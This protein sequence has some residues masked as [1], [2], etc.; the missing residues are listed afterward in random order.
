M[1]DDRVEAGVEQS[2]SNATPE[3]HPVETGM[4]RDREAA[5][6]P[7]ARRWAEDGEH[8]PSRTGQNEP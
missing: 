7:A 5:N 6:H 3:R 1:R 8:H 4:A 2:A